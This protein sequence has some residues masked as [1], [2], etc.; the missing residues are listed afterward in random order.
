M[1]DVSIIDAFR[2]SMIGLMKLLNEETELLKKRE[3]KTLDR[4][5]A[6]KRQLAISFEKHQ[7]EMRKHPEVLE[8]I[9]SDDRT[10]LREIY[11]R[12][13]CAL[14][15]NML[16]LRSSHDA[17][18]RVVSLIMESVRKQRGITADAIQS[19]GKTRTGYDAYTPLG[20]NVAAVTKSL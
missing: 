18:E 15:D 6:R 19:F 2:E 13:R 4:L 8:M 9:P 7:T 10:A 5:Q 1:A 12:F 17:A 16:A 20:Q 14:S 11:N 3:F